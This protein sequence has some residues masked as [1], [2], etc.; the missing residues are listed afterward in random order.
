MQAPHRGAAILTLGILG[1][2]VIFVCGIIAW[3]LGR[4]D[5][6]AMA[7]GRMDPRGEGLTR[8]GVICGIVG[9]CLGVVAIVFVVWMLTVVEGAFTSVR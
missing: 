4:A 2:C 6:K 3:V 7:E 9:T 5:L 8:A 1:I